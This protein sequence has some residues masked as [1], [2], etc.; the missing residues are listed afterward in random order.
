MYNMTLDIIFLKGAS[1]IE[2][3]LAISPLDGAN[4]LGEDFGG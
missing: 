1:R 4:C 3:G 2:T